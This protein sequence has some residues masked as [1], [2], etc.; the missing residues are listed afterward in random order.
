[1]YAFSMTKTQR[2]GRAT[3]DSYPAGPGRPL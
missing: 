1:M 3:S 2:L